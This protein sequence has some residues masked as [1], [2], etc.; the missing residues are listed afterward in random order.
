MRVAGGV[1][2]GAV[3]RETPALGL[4]FELEWTWAPA[5]AS[6]CPARTAALDAVLGTRLRFPGNARWPSWGLPVSRPGAFLGLAGGA[7]SESAREVLSSVRRT[8]LPEPLRE[9]ARA[10]ASE[11]RREGGGSSGSSPSLP[12]LS[13]RSSL[14][15]H[16]GGGALAPRGVDG[17]TGGREGDR[18]RDVWSVG[19]RGRDGGW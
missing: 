17:E 1:G 11:P 3:V 19:D 2:D 14:G 4:R 16:T 10:R 9:C 12:S 7:T 8:V 5:T 18:V 13:P 15:T 6:S